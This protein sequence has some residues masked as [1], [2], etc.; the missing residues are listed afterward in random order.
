MGS[1]NI[2]DLA[3]EGSNLWVPKERQAR[4]IQ[5]HGKSGTSETPFPGL[6][7]WIRGPLHGP[8]YDHTLT[9][10]TD[11][12]NLFTIAMIAGY[13]ESGYDDGLLNGK[14]TEWNHILGLVW[15]AGRQ[16]AVVQSRDHSL[17]QCTLGWPLRIQM[18]SRKWD[19][20]SSKNMQGSTKNVSDS[21]GL[22]HFPVRQADFIRHLP[23]GLWW[24]KLFTACLTWLNFSLVQN[25]FMQVELQC[26][27]P[28]GRVIFVE[29]C[30]CI[31]FHWWFVLCNMQCSHKEMWWLVIYQI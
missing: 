19:L 14:D 10:F 31:L 11:Q 6:S 25:S 17:S 18:I 22:V 8:C 12:L 3:N 23:G 16:F 28:K 20:E 13:Y 26:T 1:E 29:P 21:L 5:G 27:L 7:G 30:T 9:A 4:G 24:S 2:Q 15:R